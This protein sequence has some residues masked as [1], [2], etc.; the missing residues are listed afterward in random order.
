MSRYPGNASSEVEGD[1]SPGVMAQCDASEENL[2]VM[3]GFSIDAKG[4]T[5][6]CRGSPYQTD[7]VCVSR[8]GISSN[9]SIRAIDAFLMNARGKSESI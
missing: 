5:S 4:K 1:A 2:N 9:L 7:T 3:G 6:A 8:S